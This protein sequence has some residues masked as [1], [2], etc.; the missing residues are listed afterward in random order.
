[1]HEF[2]DAEWHR[3]T[4]IDIDGVF[5]RSRVVSADMFRRRHGTI[6]IGS[7]LGIV[8]DTNA[9]RLRGGKSWHAEFHTLP[10]LEVGAFGVRVNAVAPRRF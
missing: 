2:T 6:N 4:R 9:G 1:M 3:I 10:A 7:V 8:S 5:Y